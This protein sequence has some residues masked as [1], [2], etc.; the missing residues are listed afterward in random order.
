MTSHRL[1]WQGW[2]T[3]GL[4]PAQAAD[5]G[6]RPLSCGLCWCSP[7]FF[8]F[9][10]G[11]DL[12]GGRGPGQSEKVDSSLALAKRMENVWR[13]LGRQSAWVSLRRRQEERCKL[14][15]YPSGKVPVR[16]HAG[17]SMQG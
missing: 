11:P 15:K 1:K 4:C 8:L 13:G 16:G 3:A 5:A 2:S 6:A 12:L 10:L 9:P 14:T 17:V 7:S